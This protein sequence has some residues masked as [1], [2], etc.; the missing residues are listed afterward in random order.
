MIS[1]AE[2]VKQKNATKNLF[3][4]IFRG[5]FFAA[6]LSVLFVWVWLNGRFNESLEKEVESRLKLIAE[7]L[8]QDLQ[9]I[10]S[11]QN[12]V[13]QLRAMQSFWQLEKS[14]GL[15]Q[16][17]Y[18]LDVT[19]HHPEF[20]ASFSTQQIY[21]AALRPPSPEEAEELVFEYI[22]EL[23]QG[24]MVFPKTDSV[25]QNARRIK[26]LLC[27]V[28]DS[29]GMLTSVVGIE[30][31]LDF[32]KRTRE[33]RKYL[34]EIL[35]VALILSLLAAFLLA[36]TLNWRIGLL[37]RGVEIVRTGQHPEVKT[38]GLLEFDELYQSFEQMSF[39]LEKQRQNV[40]AVFSRKLDELAFTG[41][42]IAHEI[43]NPLSAIGMHFGL[44]KRKLEKSV[45]AGE[46]ATAISEI[47]QQ[48]KHLKELLQSFL[49]YTRKVVPRLELVGLKESVARIIA[50]RR[51][52][53]GNFEYE[54]CVESDLK[55]LLDPTM[56]QQILNNLINNSWKAM[57]GNELKLTV[58]AEISSKTLL[59]RF[60]DNGPGIPGKIAE[61]MFLPF[62]TSSSDGSGFG[63]AVVRKLVEAH[64]GEINFVKSD[65]GASFLIEVPQNENPGS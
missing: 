57:P 63:L 42:A 23:D 27:P 41:G 18:W 15:L 26:I 36:S 16:N 47:D 3:N 28:L 61:T 37:Q 62:S 30:T 22:N 64:G 24:Q 50:T 54:L 7:T 8:V 59:L 39:E 53:L 12:R 10:G 38:T 45:E 32:L 51:S 5:V 9:E 55:A 21:D 58:A 19:D 40:Q 31:D 43:R 29:Y 48:L 35:A 4:L 2:P 65:N 20:I 14:Q 33:F 46:Y 17:F 1:N 60:S 11:S 6:V 34:A 49:D 52:V 13:F 56:L 25:G 44:L